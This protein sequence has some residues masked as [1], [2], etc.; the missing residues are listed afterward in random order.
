MIKKEVAIDPPHQADSLKFI[1]ESAWAS[2]KGLESIKTFEN[3]VSNMENE[4]LQWRKW[5]QEEKAESAELPKSYKD[6]TLFHRLLLLRSIRP[7]RLSGALT[8]F[9]AS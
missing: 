6:C 5:Y 3:L 8:E 2:V 7:D 4:A 1:P 9:V